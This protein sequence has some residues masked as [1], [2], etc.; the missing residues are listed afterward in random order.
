MNHNFHIRDYFNKFEPHPNLIFWI[1]MIKESLKIAPNNEQKNILDFGCGDGKFLHLYAMMDKFENGYGIELSEELINEAN[2]EKQNN[3]NYEKYSKEFFDNKK[4][5]FDIVYSQEVI[6]TIED[7]KMHAKEIFNIVKPDGYYFATMGSHIQNPLWSH[8]RD[9]IREDFNQGKSHYFAYDYSL[10]EVA[11]IFKE[12][13]FEVGLKRLPLEYFMVYGENITREFSN[14][15][16]DLVKT[17]EEEK[18]LFLF[19][20]PNL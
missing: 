8:R 17:S 20:K 15:L 14:S 13:G 7:L 19:W 3:M 12:V 2:K 9:V 18:M 1:S 4:N 6:Y 11:K 5:Y 16:Y 10:D